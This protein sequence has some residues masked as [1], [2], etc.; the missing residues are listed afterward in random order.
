MTN[1]IKIGS[2][3]ITPITD[4]S[5]ELQHVVGTLIGLNQRMAKIEL[6]TGEVINVGKTKIE[7]LPAKKPTKKNSPEGGEP[8]GR[9]AAG[10]SYEKTTA[11]SGRKSCDNGDA[12]AIDLRG[13]ELADCYRIVSKAIGVPRKELEDKYRHLNPGQQRM[14]IG[15]RLRGF[16]R[17]Q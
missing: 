16:I 7:I 14:C 6:D 9:I 12:I 2:T 8:A 10:Y 1:L 3:V 15:N 13:R 5:G 4:D 11:A 17:N